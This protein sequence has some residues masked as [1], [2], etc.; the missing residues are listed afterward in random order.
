MHGP[1]RPSHDCH[2]RAA[3]LILPKGNSFGPV[4][5]TNLRSRW[6]VLFRRESLS[7]GELVKDRL[8]LVRMTRKTWWKRFLSSSGAAWTV[9]GTLY[10][11]A[12][13]AYES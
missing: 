4:F 8:E 13:Q 11:L 1:R 6:R 7:S 2:K 9:T 12:G 5:S 3:L 10:V